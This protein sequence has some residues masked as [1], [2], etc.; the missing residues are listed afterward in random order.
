MQQIAIRSIPEFV[1]AWQACTA[2]QRRE[3]LSNRTAGLSTETF[4]AMKERTTQVMW[5]DVQAALDLAESMREAANLTGTPAHSAAAGIAL[6]NVYAFGLGQY[7]RAM[8]VYRDATTAA[9]DAG[10]P[11]LAAQTRIPQV[12]VLGMLARYTEALS[13]GERVREAAQDRDDWLTYVK[14][15]TNMAI[16]CRRR[17]D[18]G[19]ALQ[20]YDE[21][22]EALQQYLTNHAQ[23]H[24]LLYMLEL[25]RSTTLR[26][27]NRY[28][29]AIDAARSALAVAESLETPA[30]VA[31]AHDNL[32]LTYFLLGKY[33]DSLACYRK[34]RG[35]FQDAH[36]LRDSVVV[37]L[38]EAQCLLMLNDLAAVEETCSNV[39]DFSRDVGMDHEEGIALTYR[40]TGRRRRKKH[41]LAADDL[42]R[43]EDIFAEHENDSWLGQVYL[44]MAHLRLDRGD[45]HEASIAAS[46][47]QVC[48]ERQELRIERAQAL[49]AQALVT[50]RQEKYNVA[51]R[52]YREVRTVG[53]EKGLAWLV[54]PACHG[55]AR[56]ARARGHCERARVRL[57]QA[58][59][60]VERL[61]G[62][63]AMELRVS[64]LADKLDIFAD[65]VALALEADDTA[66]ALQYVERA[67]SRALLDMFHEEDS[68]RLQAL[69]PDDQDI[70]GEINRLREQR[71]WFEQRM[72]F[73]PMAAGDE[74]MSVEERETWRREAELCEERIESLFRDLQVRNASY[75]ATRTLS[76]LPEE[77]V[78]PYLRVETRLIE[79]YV[80][81]DELW[82]FVVTPDDVQARRLGA[83]A[84]V[85]DLL[86]RWQLQ[87]TH[88][89]YLGAKASRHADMAKQI[90]SRLYDVLLAPLADQLGDARRLYVVPH[91]PLHTLPFSALYDADAGE[92]L[93][94]RVAVARLPSSSVLAALVQRRQ[95][96]PHTGAPLILGH[97]CDGALPQTIVEAE[98]VSRITD[99]ELYAESEASVT[100]LLDAEHRR[101]LIHVAA[102]GRFRPDAPLFSAIYLADGSLTALDMFNTRL[103]TELLVF[104]ACESGRGAVHPGDEVVG[105]SRACLHAGAQSLLL[106]L[107]RVEDRST[108]ALMETF[109]RQLAADTTPADA[110]CAAQCRHLAEPETA[111][112][113]HWAGFSITGD[114][115][116]PI[117]L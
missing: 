16:A 23:Y 74:E 15:T 18:Y 112:P 36:L 11:A 68:I 13:I 4:V 53:K 45:L 14:V 3:F 97:S 111:H 83:V 10:D 52:A 88:A 69:D 82:A 63:M 87:L 70:V 58:M 49:L 29:Q 65:A 85:D 91:G 62:G 56:V 8:S 47:A 22:R 26:Y 46:A 1:D 72:Q 2:D 9:E 39:I 54:Y 43:A 109:Y 113:F 19:R 32:G 75:T 42:D 99:G 27:L 24:E 7:E 116:V 67:K 48:F 114:A 90:L 60:A 95:R 25:N 110:L 78:G 108:G 86:S 100:R 76:A 50:E 66:G 101:P 34:A 77:P 64:F 102:H 105:L 51:R 79:Y 96:E 117:R 61:R 20:Y 37:Q 12:Y 59:K 21:H 44:E 81:R 33:N 80:L 17:G 89:A 71:R 104:S 107:W 55:L 57:E 94:E 35:I 84:P 106:S 28:Q 5:S 30:Y 93:I 6:G 115:F 40:A 41:E 38:F 73:R 103:H 92:Y 98:L 31:R